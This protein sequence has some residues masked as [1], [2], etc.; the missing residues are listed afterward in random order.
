MA[1]QTI[2]DNITE[3][4]C[5][6]I[7]KTG[8]MVL[9]GIL[10]I[11]NPTF[12]YGAPAVRKQVSEVTKELENIGID[13]EMVKRSLW[14]LSHRKYIKRG[15]DDK[16]G[17]TNLGFNR[18]NKLIPSYHKKRPWNKIMYLITYDIPEKNKKDRDQLRQFLKTNNFGLLQD[19]VWLTLF[20]P[21]QLL[22]RFVLDFGIKGNIIISSLGRDG[23]IGEEDLDDLLQR[24]YSLKQ[25]NVRYQQLIE[26]IHI[27]GQIKSELVFQY[28]SILKDDPQLPFE[29]L[30]FNWVGDKCFRLLNESL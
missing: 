29:L 9:F 13:K 6:L 17:L 15:I 20:N 4:T 2:K 10:L 11:A 26:T 28:L 19:S 5:G 24:V 14:K 8:D 27:G 16:I 7:A 18:I 25:I 21:K 3:I 30:P 1:I 23:S 22:H 12:T